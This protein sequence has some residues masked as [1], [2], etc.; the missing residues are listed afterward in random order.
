MPPKTIEAERMAGNRMMIETLW[1]CGFPSAIDRDR[2][3]DVVCAITSPELWRLL[4]DRRKWSP[5]DSE[6]WIGDVLIA[7]LVPNPQAEN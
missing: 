1:R 5:D 6:T 3:A 2:A 7:Q 4:A